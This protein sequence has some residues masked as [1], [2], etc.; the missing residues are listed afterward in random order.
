MAGTLTDRDAVERYLAQVLADV[1]GMSSAQVHPRRPLKRQGLD[2]L[3]AV[4]VRTRVQRDLGMMLPIAKMLGGHSV[5]E[6]AGE[7]FSQLGDPGRH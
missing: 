3:M 1:L 7:V 5:A 6:L 2:S 4:E